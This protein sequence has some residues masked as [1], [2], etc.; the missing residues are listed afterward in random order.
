MTKRLLPLLRRIVGRVNKMID[1]FLAWGNIYMPIGVIFWVLAIDKGGSDAWRFFI[2]GLV[3]VLVG[4]VA[5]SKA[6]RKVKT[7]EKEEGER[8][9]KLI[10]EIRGLRKALKPKGVNKKR[11]KENE[12]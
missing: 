4:L 6:W 5:M 8:F 10:T 3:F 9:K 1:Y 12:Q 11:A 2:I 7:L